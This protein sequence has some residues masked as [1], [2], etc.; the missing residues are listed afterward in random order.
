MRFLY[1][2]AV[3][4]SIAGCAT[5]SENIAASYVSPMTYASY[6]CN[7]LREEAARI[8]SRVVQVTGAQD[9]KATG[10]AIATGVGVIIFWPALFLIKG[11][12]T[13]AAEL[14][15]LRGEM[16]AIEQTSTQKQCGIRFQRQ[17]SPGSASAPT[18]AS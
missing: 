10:D 8:S 6:N 3:A 7:Q 18:S 12:S 2:F 13:T 14:A 9:Q 5:R 15:R 17:P 16:D 4:L 1:C 11:D